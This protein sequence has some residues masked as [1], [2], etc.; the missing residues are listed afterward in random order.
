MKTVEIIGYNRANLG[1]TE[2]KQL[3]AEGNVPCVIYGGEK[4]IH[5]YSPMILFREIVY[6]DL[7]HFVSINV[8]GNIVQ[9][10]LQDIQFHPVSEAILHA[11]FLELHKGKLINMEIPVDFQGTPVGVTNGG[12]LVKKRRKLTVRAIPKDM[13]ETITVDVSNLDFGTSLK[14]GDL[15]VE[16]YNVLDPAQASIAVIEIPRALRSAQDAE[17]DELGEGEEGEESIEGEEGTTPA[18]GSDAP[19]AE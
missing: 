3:R 16:G 14:V 11:D 7:A 1:K 12:L 17:D 4:Q 10:I 13:P 2:A 15:K 6:T 5:F 19:A 8:E 18:L 9:A